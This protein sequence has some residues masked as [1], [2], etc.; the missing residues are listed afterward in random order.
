[1]VQLRGSR[2]EPSTQAANEFQFLV[3]QLR[4]SIVIEEVVENPFQFLVVQLRAYELKNNIDGKVVS[5]PCGTIKSLI[6]HRDNS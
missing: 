3:V 5:I 1:M 4:G 2:S 6:L